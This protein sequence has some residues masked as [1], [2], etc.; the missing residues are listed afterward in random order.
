MKTFL[1]LLL[2]RSL[3]M[4]TVSEIRNPKDEIGDILRVEA[5]QKC[6]EA[7]ELAERAGVHVG[8]YLIDCAII[9]LRDPKR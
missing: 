4:P 9:E 8:A 1:S 7:R 5:I 2:G 6:M 3:S